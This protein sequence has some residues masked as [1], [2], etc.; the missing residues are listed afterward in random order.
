V[1]SAPLPVNGPIRFEGAHPAEVSPH[2]KLASPVE[3]HKL[4]HKS[5]YS[6]GHYYVW[7]VI[8]VAAFVLYGLVLFQLMPKFSQESVENVERYGASFGLGVLLF[9]G[10]PI[11]ALIACATVVG[12]FIGITTFFLWYAALYYAQIV[13]G[14]AV[15]QWI[16]GKTR[17]IWPLI[18]RMALG[19]IIVRLCTTIPAVG[20]W[21]KFG[22]MLWGI[23]AT[24]LAL[25]RRLQPAV[26]PGLPSGPSPLP[27]TTTIGGMQPA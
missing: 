24:S 26:A 27:P 10:I 9:F 7:Q 13:V 17:E 11:A 6:E 21:V 25:Y 19:V 18:G 1:G 8:W 4:E 20:G 5:K 2:A 3:Y 22:L 14:A 16:L 12:L 23:G 15:G